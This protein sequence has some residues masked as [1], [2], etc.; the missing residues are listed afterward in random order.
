MAALVR[1]LD[2]AATPLGALAA[3]P[4]SLRS[5][6]DIC[7][8][9]GVARFV[10]WGSELVQIYNDVALPIMGTRHPAAFGVPARQAWHDAW[11]ALGPLVERILVTAEPAVQEDLPMVSNR[12]GACEP[13]WYSFYCSALRN[14]AGAVAGLF[15]TVVETTAKVQAQAAQR[16]SEARLTLL[17]EQTAV[18]LSE[19]APD[20]RFLAVNAEL[21]RIV[22]RSPQAMRSLAIA[23]VAHPD[24][25][26]AILEATVQVLARG[27]PARVEMRYLRPDGTLVVTQNSVTR[28]VA[29]QEH[30]PRLFLVTEDLT[31]RREAEAALRES[32]ARL[33]AIADLVPDL[34]WSSD[35]QGRANWTNG[36]WSEYTGQGEQQALGEGW[37]AAIHPEDLPRILARWRRATDRRLPLVTECRLR[38]HDGPFRWHL[39]RAAPLRDGQGRIVRWFCSATD[40]QEQRSARDSLE[41]HVKER[42]RQLEQAVELRRELLARM[43]G[44]QDDERRRIARELHDSLGQFLSAMSLSVV[45]FQQCLTDSA[46]LDHLANLRSLLESVDRELDRIVFTLRPTALDDGGLG[47]AVTAYVATWSRLADVPVDLLL[48]GLDEARLSPRIEAAVFR[49]IQEALTNVAKHAGASSVSVSVERLHRQLVASVE[50]DGAG[51][52]HAEAQPL[53]QGRPSWGLLGMKERIEVLGGTFVIESSAGAGTTVLMRVP[54]A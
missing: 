50:D 9:G 38:R 22:G 13:A 46:A 39:M 33:S 42:T 37:T 36:R 24:D 27:G 3:W 4:P 15:I 10:W 12:E 25:V 20:A 47:E 17:S 49:V 7:L 19:I 40:I 8:D 41:R 44:L 14:E 21:G 53:E 45:A 31:A 51:F 18:G 5:A 28:L 2:W 32:E 29:G 48:R 16:E 43:E 6:V 54:L 11:E 1:K 35:P 26:A 30:G 34:L 52:D 23:D